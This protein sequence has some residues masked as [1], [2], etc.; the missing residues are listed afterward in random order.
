MSLIFVSFAAGIVLIY[1]ID[2]LNIFFKDSTFS[3]LREKSGDVRWEI[4]AVVLFQFLVY[5]LSSIIFVVAVWI[6]SERLL[7][8]DE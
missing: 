5:V 3:L 4:L 1:W 6:T 2:R 8:K 7:Y